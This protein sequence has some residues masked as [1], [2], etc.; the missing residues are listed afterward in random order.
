VPQLKMRATDAELERFA[1]TGATMEIVEQRRR[2][3]EMDRRFPGILADAIRKLRANGFHSAKAVAPAE[4]PKRRTLS[5]EAR[6][7][8][9]LA[10]K[11]RWAK[12]RKEAKAS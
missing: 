4:E 2:H 10:Q 8:I 1:R 11:R 5:K 7:R 9:S 6:R 12:K 3:L